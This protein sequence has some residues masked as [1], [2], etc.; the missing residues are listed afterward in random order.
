MSFLLL[1]LCQE[2]AYLPCE[3]HRPQSVQVS[4]VNSAWKVNVRIQSKL[5]NEHH[6]SDGGVSIDP[7]QPWRNFYSAMYWIKRYGPSNR[8]G[9]SGRGAGRWEAPP[10]LHMVCYLD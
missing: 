3:V 10:K 8:L 5:T 7:C 9:L 6:S 2:V 4:R 1:F